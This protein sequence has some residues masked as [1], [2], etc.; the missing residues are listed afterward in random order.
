M[1]GRGHA[2]GHGRVAASLQ[3]AR[4]GGV[5]VDAEGG[6]GDARTPNR[7]TIGRKKGFQAL[8]MTD[9]VDDDDDDDVD[10]VHAKGGGNQQHGRGTG[11][12]SRGGG[13]GDARG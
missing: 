6:V 3:R 4:D 12:S 13:G 10:D 7:F 9:D 2:I 1:V 5:D 11:S 8:S